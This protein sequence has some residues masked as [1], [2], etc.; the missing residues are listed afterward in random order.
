MDNNKPKKQIKNNSLGRL[1]NN[2]A[3]LENLLPS[4]QDTKKLRE[5]WDKIDDVWKEILLI[6]YDFRKNFSMKENLL[7]MNHSSYHLKMKYKNRLKKV[8]SISNYEI[9]DD[10]LKDILKLETL[11]AA[12]SGI[13]ECSPVSKLQNLRY[14]DI[15]NNFLTDVAPVL[16]LKYLIKLDVNNNLDLADSENIIGQ[17][18]LLKILWIY[19]TKI[20]LTKGRFDNLTNLKSII[21]INNK[22]D[23][24]FD[25]NSMPK[26][27]HLYN[28]DIIFNSKLTQKKYPNLKYLLYDNYAKRKNQMNINKIKENNPHIILSPRGIFSNFLDLEYF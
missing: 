6:N 17:L 12:A 18:Y 7:S 21:A 20:S 14:L 23:D 3:N 28:N 8:F 1:E 24:D 15:S 22:I 25:L 26:F 13:K 11:D 9:T 27:E 19:K 4:V 16:R 10:L 2:L 5:W